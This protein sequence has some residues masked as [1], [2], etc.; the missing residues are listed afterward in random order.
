MSGYPALQS[1]NENLHLTELKENFS[2]LSEIQQLLTIG[3]FYN[4]EVT[5]A[6][7]IHTLEAFQ[8]FKRQ[9]YLEYPSVLGRTTAKELL[10]IGGIGAHPQPTE[11]IKEPSS[12]SKGKSFKLPTNE[13]VY[14]DLPI[15]GCKNFSWGEATK[16]GARIPIS[17]D[18]VQ[19]ITRVAIVLDAARAI[20]GDRKMAI[21][22]WYRPIAINRAVGGIDNSRHI[23]GDGVDFVVQGMNPLA[24]YKVLSPWLGD[25]GG[26][27]KSSSFTHLDTR[28]YRARWDYGG[29]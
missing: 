17:R 16:N 19:R 27:G 21:T 3:K 18:V 8:T 1:Y 28:G 10:E 20:L 23:V 6:L 24:V 5:G 22:S 4:G 26:L 12:S 14:C 29:A 7:N 13:V 2:L 11:A 15:F 25:R 9:A